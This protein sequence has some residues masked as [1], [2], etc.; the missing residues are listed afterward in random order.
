[1]VS[2]E[3]R[4]ADIT[5]DVE[6][7]LLKGLL[8]SFLQDEVDE[9]FNANRLRDELASLQQ[10]L[11]D[12]LGSES[13]ADGSIDIE[14]P[15]SDDDQ[16]MALYELL[17][18][19]ARFPLT[20]DFLRTNRL[21]IIAAL[22][23]DDQDRIAEILEDAAFCELT[24]NVQVALPVNEAY[25]W[26]NGAC[27]T[28]DLNVAGTYFSDAA[29]SESF[30]YFPT[31]F[32][33]FCATSLVSSRLGNAQSNSFELQR[34]SLSPGTRF[35]VGALPVAGKQQPYVQRVNYKNAAGSGGNC[36]LEMRVYKGNPNAQN[37][38]PRNTVC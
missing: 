2:G 21:E 35:E 5:V 9:L 12:S 27:V 34:W 18:P 1:V 19:Q 6:N 24:S 26:S 16:I 14:L 29:C 20:A 25:Q 11:N 37:L 7:T 33:E 15:P 22:I 10:S 31:S 23:F 8:E 13:S 17:T 4:E 30:D 3:L 28:A 32:S 38:K 36:A